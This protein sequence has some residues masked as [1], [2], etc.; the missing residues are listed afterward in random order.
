MSYAEKVPSAITRTLENGFLL[1]II[2]NTQVKSKLWIA[3]SNGRKHRENVAKFKNSH[4]TAARTINSTSTKRN[5]EESITSLS[6]L[7]LKKLKDDVK[8][9]TSSESTPW[10]KDSLSKTAESNT[11]Y[12]QK[13]NVIEG[14]PEGFFEDKKLNSRVIDTIE[15]QANIEQQYID[16]M[17]ELDEAKEE[18]QHREEDEEHVVAIE[19][20][21]AFIDEQIDQWKRVNRLELRRDELYNVVAEKNERHKEPIMM[22]QISDDDSDVDL[23]GWRNKGI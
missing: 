13:K 11:K 6:T 9:S 18:E 19:H 2:C 4:L 8:E 21:I 16:F 10:E 14:V 1:C 22:G 3:H 20:D 17:R 7:P 12:S 15:K 23:T 5:P